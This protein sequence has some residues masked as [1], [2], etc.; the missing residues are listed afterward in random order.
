[1]KCKAMR[2]FD[3]IM[4]DPKNHIRLKMAPGDMVTVKNMRVLHGRCVVHV[5]RGVVIIMIHVAQVRA[6]GRGEREASAVWL[7]GLGRDPV[8]REHIVMNCHSIHHDC[9]CRSTIRVTRKKLG[10]PL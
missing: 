3:D 9:V 6:G 8:S 2:T 1:M 7:H 10:L 4:N 5:A